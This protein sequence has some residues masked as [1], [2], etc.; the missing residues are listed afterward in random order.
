MD[1][2]DI[3]FSRLYSSIKR[4]LQKWY[5]MANESFDLSSPFGMILRTTA[6]LFQLNKVNISNA[7][8][9]FD[10]N[11]SFN[12]NTKNI[13]SLARLGQYNPMRG[14]AANGSIKIRL[15]PN[16]DAV[17]ETG[18]SYII[19]RNGSKLINNKNNLQYSLKLNQSE[20]MFS[21]DSN[22]PIYLDV[23]QGIY[24]RITFTGTGEINQSFII[25]GSTDGE[26]DQYDIRVFVNSEEWEIKKHKHD[27]LHDEN[28]CV[29]YTGFTGGVDLLFGNI[30]EGNVPPLG[31]IIEVVYLVHNGVAGNLTNFEANDFDFMDE[32]YNRMGDDVD[33]EEIADILLGSNINYG[34]DGDTIEDLKD[35]VPYAS[36]N[37][38]L[39]G[40]EQYKFFLKR[41]KIFSTI[42]V[43]TS[44]KSD[45]DIKRAIYELAKEN[46]EYFNKISDSDEANTIKILVEKNLREIQLLR[47]L[48]ISDGTEGLINILLIPDIKTY[49]GRD[50]KLNYFNIDIDA[51]TLNED[52]KDRILNYLYQDGIQ[53]VTNEVRIINPVI[54]KYAVNVTVSIFEK[55]REGNVINEIISEVSNYFLNEI[56]RD[57]IP[58]SDLVRIID[59]N[60]KGVDSVIVEFISEQTEEYHKEYLQKAKQYFMINGVKPRDIDIIMSDGESFNAEKTPGLDPLLGD[61]VLNLDEF[62]LIRGG[63]TDRYNNKYSIQPGD[64]E[65]SPINVLILPQ[66]SKRT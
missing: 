48:Y 5:S 6:E 4:E 12:R 15:K 20:L 36:P 42:D 64:G 29:V 34:S 14:V 18:D 33:L 56:R 26:I 65:Y 7:I 30:S 44:P 59:S 28:S 62:P 61:I 31:S 24:K 51:F 39:S 49:F 27:L 32:P 37:F 55:E 60:V 35:I 38:V 43:F 54:R 8:R 57:K 3:T 23:V 40:P 58:A 10:L 21:L 19:F 22:I 16:V 46:I 17:E 9:T 25:P 53:T 2:Q 50:K 1:L 52:D 13:R 45:A 11:D 63:F 41:L 66:R 47:K